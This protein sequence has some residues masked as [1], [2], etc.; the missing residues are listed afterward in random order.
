[1]SDPY[2]I[3]EVF[4]ELKSTDTSEAIFI[5]REAAGRIAAGAAFTLQAVN[6]GA[7]SGGYTVTFTYEMTV[8]VVNCPFVTPTGA[9]DI[10]GEAWSCD[11]AAADE[12][13][14]WEVQPIACQ[15]LKIVGTLTGTLTNGL[16]VYLILW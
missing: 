11:A 8:S 10:M 12:T 2:Q 14:A 15:A 16:K 5:T 7:E 6:L 4:S 3:V 9:T 13:E 1:M